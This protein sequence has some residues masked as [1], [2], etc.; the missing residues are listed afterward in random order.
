M[1]PITL[2]AIISFVA[3]QLL[4]QFIKDQGYGRIKRFI[5]PKKKYITRLI[6]LIY[7]T[8]DEFE[9]DHPYDKNSNK[10]PFYH[11]QVIFDRLLKH[12]LFKKLDSNALINEFQKYPSILIPTETELEDFFALFVKKVNNDSTLSKLHLEEHFKQEIFE[13]STNLH[14][15]INTINQIKNDVSLIKDKALSCLTADELLDAL[16]HQ[17]D[18]QISKQIHSGKYIP[19]TFIETNELKDH[20]RYFSS[21]YFFYQKVLDEIQC[22][23]FR[24][25]N[26]MRRLNNEKNFDYNVTDLG[27]DISSYSFKDFIG[28]INALSSY[29][30]V[31]QTELKNTGGNLSYSFTLKI[32]ERIEDLSFISSK[33]LVITDNA[34]QGKTNLLCD[35]AQNVLLKRAIPAIFLTGYEINAIDIKP[36]FAKQIFLK[37]DYTFKDLLKVIEEISHKNKSCFVILIDGLNENSNPMEFSRNLEL[38]ISELVQY[39]FVKIILTC[40]TEYFKNNF[41]NILLSDFK[42]KII[43]VNRLNNKLN[44]I[45]KK[46]LYNVYCRHFNLQIG[47]ISEAIYKQLVDN[48]LLLRIFSESYHGQQLPSVNHIYK[49]ELFEKYYELICNE[50]NKRLT[51]NDELK[52]KGSF[53]IRKFLQKIIEYM[54]GKA[55]FSNIPLDVILQ[56]EPYYN[57]LYIRFLDENILVRKDL[58][59]DSSTLFGDTEV[60]NFT[61]DEFRDYLISSYLFSKVYKDSKSDFK[62][63][64]ENNLTESSAIS[65]GCSTFL[66]SLE[67]KMHDDYLSDFIKKQRWYEKTFFYCIFNIRDSE[68]NAAD[69]SLLIKLFKTDAHFSHDITLELA[70][71]RYDVEAYPNLNIRF[72]FELFN[73]LTADEFDRLVYSIYSKN[74]YDRNDYLNRLVKQL[75]TILNEKDF[76]KT[77]GYHNIFEYLLYL[78]PLSWDVK[79]LYA[80]YWGKYHNRKHFENISKCK[81]VELLEELKVFT[82]RYGVQL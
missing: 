69:K 11:S 30:T 77:K 2:S 19:D 42:D 49:D 37:S 63:F 29:L 75:E 34:G 15:L 53:D 60:V 65:E 4:S 6:A 46:R 70:Y 57:D 80:K 7:E 44:E 81:S 16:T 38:F 35:L 33:C 22:L 25:L 39:P 18:R 73:E 62:K 56:N 58:K 51:Q 14:K 76:E 5:F 8:T 26:R 67:R 31:K 64:V 12:I 79:G 24:H 45:Q 3:T 74:G 68:V 61:F 28:L 72:L 21:P 32:D 23:D 78:I 82:K 20:L 13:I 55:Q 1:E 52:R 59:I 43:E 10:F 47:N 66:F 17:V 50:I 41:S 9:K 48:F 40:R 54:I 71:Q 36:S 27:V